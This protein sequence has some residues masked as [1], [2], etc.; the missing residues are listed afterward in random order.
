MSDYYLLITDGGKALEAAAHASG[1][2]VK[3]TKFAVGDGG[4]AAVTPDAAQTSLVNET[5]RDVLSSLAVSNDDDTVLEAECIIP[6][7]SGGYTIRE[8]G[9]YADDGTL[10]AVGN[11]ADQDKPAPDSGYA[12]ALQIFADLAV[13]DTSDITLTV[14]DGSYLTEAQGNTLYLRQDKLLAEI[15]GQ[16]EDA[17][18]AA[19]DNLGMGTAATYDITTSG[20]DFTP[21]RVLKVGDYGLGIADGSEPFLNS[22][23]DIE[24]SGEYNAL[25]DGADNPTEGVPAGSGNTRF[26]VSVGNIYANQYLVTLTSNVHFYVGVVDTAKKTS[27]WSKF[28]NT[29]NK[30]SASDVGAM[31]LYEDPL[32]V[33]LSTL[34]TPDAAGIYTQP[35]G[36]NAL[37][38]LHYPTQEAGTLLVT[39]LSSSLGCLQE[40]TTTS[41]RKFTCLQPLNPDVNLAWQEYYSE[42]NPPPQPDLSAYETIADANARFVQ[43]TR[44]GANMSVTWGS[45]GGTVPAGCSLTGGNFDQETEYAQYAYMQKLVNGTWYNCGSE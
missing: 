38:E 42:A 36:D 33:N 26:A 5:F 44:F 35:D 1:T 11:F 15:T 20:T 41:G 14:Q 10:Y 27:T 7:N 8:I 39:P 3:L 18:Q 30:P 29:L 31:P 32:T 17:Q 34:G 24:C 43:D 4:G 6:S 12:A 25:G 19:R 16:G 2:T 21:D 28:Y 13:S 9:I 40:Y 37:P 22:I 45:G 23:Y